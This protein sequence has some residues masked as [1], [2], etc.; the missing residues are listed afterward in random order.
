MDMHV[1]TKYAGKKRIRHVFCWKRSKR[2]AS[3]GHRDAQRRSFQWKRRQ[4]R[5]RP[6]RRRRVLGELNR[7]DCAQGGRH[8][9]PREPADRRNAFGKHVSKTELSR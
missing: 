3:E 7:L 2:V 1:Y 8:A 5:A 9:R 4:M 6:E